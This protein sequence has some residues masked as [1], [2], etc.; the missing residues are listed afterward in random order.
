MT[1]PTPARG[2]TRAAPRRSRGEVPRLTQ[3]VAKSSISMPKRLAGAQRRAIRDRARDRQQ[4][5][6]VRRQRAAVLEDALELA[7]V[8]R[9]ARV[10]REGRAARRSAPRRARRRA[11][12]RPRGSSTCR[13]RSRAP[14]ARTGRA[15]GARCRAFAAGACRARGP[16]RATTRAPT[17][18]ASTSYAASSS[19]PAARARRATMGRRVP[20]G[21]ADARDHHGDRVRVGI[22]QHGSRARA[23]APRR[24]RRGARRGSRACAVRASAAHARVRR[25]AISQPSDLSSC[26]SRRARRRAVAPNSCASAAIAL[27]SSST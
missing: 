18:H 26:S 22:E 1:Q 9:G 15:A 27:S 14:R 17:S 19:Q 5:V 20:G 21:R 6:G 25:A 7:C 16:P 8:P 2:A 24:C 10:R 12:P 13:A 4:H 3:P 23:A 11:R